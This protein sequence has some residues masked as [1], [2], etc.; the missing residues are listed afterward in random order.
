LL[1]AQFLKEVRG[2]IEDGVSP[3][4]IMKG[5][6]QA[7]KIVRVVFFCSDTRSTDSATRLSIASKRFKSQSTKVIPSE[8]RCRPPR[9]TTLIMT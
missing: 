1:A 4:I 6:Q 7:S 8:S 5:F 2:Y 3:H 9:V